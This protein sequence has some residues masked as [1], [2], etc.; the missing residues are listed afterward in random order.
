MTK[1]GFQSAVEDIFGLS[2]GS[3]KD[4]DGRDN[5]SGWT[6][7]ADVQLFTVISSEFGI[8]PDSELVEAERVG[9]LMRILEDRGAFQ[10]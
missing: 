1:T 2:P 8:E 3:L 9:D 4:E 6:S 7:L 5:I 10:A